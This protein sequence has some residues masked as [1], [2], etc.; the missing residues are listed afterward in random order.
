MPDKNPVIRITYAPFI[1]II[2]IIGLSF[3]SGCVVIS[4]LQNDL[5]AAVG[6]L[7]FD[8]LIFLLLPVVFSKIEFRYEWDYFLFIC[9]NCQYKINYSNCSF[10]NQEGDKTIVHFDS[11]N[12]LRLGYIFKAHKIVI[13]SFMINGDLFLRALQINCV[14]DLSEE[15]NGTVIIKTRTEITSL[16]CFCAIVILLLYIFLMVRSIS[17]VHLS[18]SYYWGSICFISIILLLLSALVFFKSRKIIYTISS[19]HIDYIHFGSVKSIPL[20][21]ITAI[22]RTNL[23]DA[24]CIIYSD[25]RT[26]KRLQIYYPNSQVQALIKAWNSTNHI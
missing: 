26:V 17:D 15:K 6:F 4:Y 9:W 1:K 20:I 11:E 21:W 10:Y 12:Q 16:L 19:E 7:L 24:I 3:F 8:I 25:D 14:K 23:A 13:D 2:I 22:R 5:P 18:D